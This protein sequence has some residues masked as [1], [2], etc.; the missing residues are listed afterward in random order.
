M[1]FAFITLFLIERKKKKILIIQL[2]SLVRDE[3]TF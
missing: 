3:Y 1:H 2:K